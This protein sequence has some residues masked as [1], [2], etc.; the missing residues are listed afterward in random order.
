MNNNSTEVTF[1]S[2]LG[3]KLVLIVLPFTK[4]DEEI[5]VCINT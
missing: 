1:S 2:P 5:L 3:C 4:F